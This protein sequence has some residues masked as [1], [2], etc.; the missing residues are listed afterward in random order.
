MIRGSGFLFG[1]TW[2][3]GH[4]GDKMKRKSLRA[5]ISILFL[6]IIFIIIIS[7]WTEVAS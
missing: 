3:L 2:D 1:L 4:D 6:I 7:H 5:D